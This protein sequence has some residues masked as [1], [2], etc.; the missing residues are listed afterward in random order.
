MK[1][2]RGLRLPSQPL[3]HKKISTVYLKGLNLKEYIENIRHKLKPPVSNALMFSGKQLKVMIV[4]GPNQRNDFHLNNG[5]E[6]YFQLSGDMNLDVIDQKNEVKRIPIREESIFLLPSNVPHSPQRYEN[7]VGMVIERER[8][9]SEFDGLRWYSLS[10]TS[11]DSM[12]TRILY[13]EF[14]HCTD[15]GTQLRPIIEKFNNSMEKQS[16]IP[17]KDYEKCVESNGYHKMFPFPN[18]L[19]IKSIQPQHLP[20]WIEN[21]CNIGVS[22][23]SIYDSEFKATLQVGP[24]IDKLS[25]AEDIAGEALLWQQDGCSTITIPSKEYG[26][27]V[28]KLNTGEV[29]LLPY[30]KLSFVKVELK[31]SRDKLLCIT[32][33]VATS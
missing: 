5:E 18:N 17:S 30:H 32:N 2:L 23:I 9:Q 7:T 10:T 33:K 28:L 12:K 11:D 27:K 6:L 19:D 8:L 22:T 13:E 29:F 21:N 31:D 16:G 26:N 25:L 14:F 1:A 15:L 20:K 3:T 4:G 24:C